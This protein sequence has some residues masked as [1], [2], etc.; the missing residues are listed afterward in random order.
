MAATAASTTTYYCNDGLLIAT[1]WNVVYYVIIVVIIVDDDD[2]KRHLCQC[3]SFHKH[4]IIF[5]SIINPIF[6][7]RVSHNVQ[8]P[9]TNLVLLLNDAR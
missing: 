3:Q 8:D 2:D 5:K 4:K 6:M 9:L 7:K 1:Q